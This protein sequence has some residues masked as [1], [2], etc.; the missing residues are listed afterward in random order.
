[1]TETH[2]KKKFDRRILIVAAFIVVVIG[3]GIGGAAY[4]AA[5]TKTVY[6]DQSQIQAPVVALS[7]TQPGILR[8]VYV[9]PGD[10]IAANTVVAQ[11]G[12]ELIKSTAGGLVIDTNDNIGKQVGP[13]DV[14]V[15][16]IDPSQLRVVGQVQEDKGL[17][18]IKVGDP[19]VFTVDAFG[20]EKFNGVVDEVSPTSHES[21][22]VFNISDQRQEQTFDIKVSFDVAGNPQLKNGMSAKIWVYKN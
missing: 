14:V 9:S 1:M 11:V 13:S 12:I 21:D 16:T 17:S 7:P 4:Y 5:S 2:T 18:S 6:I 3:G 20:S 19:A 22:I 10:T 8:A 15:S